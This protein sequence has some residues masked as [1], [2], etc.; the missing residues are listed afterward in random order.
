MKS[1]SPVIEKT[2]AFIISEIFNKNKN[3]IVYIGKDEREIINIKNKLSWVFPE[4][5]I[6][7]YK[8]WDQIPYDNISPSKEIQTS[9]LETIYYLD[10]KKRHLGG[11]ILPSKELIDKLFF[12]M[13]SFNFLEE[14]LEDSVFAKNTRSCIES[15]SNISAYNSLNYIVER[16]SSELKTSPVIFATGGN[17]KN[18]IENCNHTVIHVE[19]LLFEG[20]VN[21]ASK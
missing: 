9:R 6:L 16:M 7:L 17:A 15:G 21:F 4:Q 19:S 3:S 13:L 10:S 2:E 5:K 14:D 12:E 8:A 18:I 11:L 20:L 1:I